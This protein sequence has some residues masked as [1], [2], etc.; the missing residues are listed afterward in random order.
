MATT[1]TSWN[2]GRTRPTMP[3]RAVYTSLSR[4]ATLGQP[5]NPDQQRRVVQATLS[6]LAQDSP[7]ESI[8]LDEQ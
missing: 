1:L 4:G 2:P 8:R 5:G 3:P 6:L 7:L